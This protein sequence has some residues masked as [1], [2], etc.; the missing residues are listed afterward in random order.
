[1]LR[2]QITSESSFHS[3]TRTCGFCWQRYLLT[4][5]QGVVSGSWKEADGSRDAFIGSV[6]LAGRSR[7]RLPMTMPITRHGTLVRLHLY[8]L[9]HQA[10]I[11]FK[12]YL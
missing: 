12:M 1:M 8:R 10:T 2:S 7:S 11:S 6:A 4:P 5:W 3:V 9:V